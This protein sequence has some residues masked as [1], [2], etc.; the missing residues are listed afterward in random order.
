MV[1][2]CDMMKTDVLENKVDRLIII[3][4]PS[5]VYVHGNER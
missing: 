5:L 2:F 3:I 4:M 1:E